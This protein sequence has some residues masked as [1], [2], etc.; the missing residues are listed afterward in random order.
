MLRFPWDTFL[1]PNFF[2]LNII[3]E[4]NAS[5]FDNTSLNSK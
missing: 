4:N 5:Y 1:T 2:F 3:F